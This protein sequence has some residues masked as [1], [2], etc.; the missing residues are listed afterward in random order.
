M[1]LSF[2]AIAIAGFP[3]VFADT[4]YPKGHPFLTDVER[5]RT[6]NRTR[7]S[8]LDS[9]GSRQNIAYTLSA[10]G[11]VIY[12]DDMSFGPESLLLE[13]VYN[14]TDDQPRRRGLGV[15]PA[16][17]WPDATVVYKYE[18]CEARELL[19]GVVDSAIKEWKKGAPYLNFKEM[20]PSAH[21][22]ESEGILTITKHDPESYWCWSV[23]AWA[24]G[25]KGRRMNLQWLSESGG[26]S[27]GQDLSTAVHEF[28]HALGL[29][30]EHQRPDREDHI[31][32]KCENYAPWT[33]SGCPDASYPA[34]CSGSTDKCCDDWHNYDVASTALFNKYGD[35]DCNSIMHYNANNVLQS[36]PGCTINPST[37]PTQGDYDA[38]CGIY[39]NECAPWKAVNFCTT[40]KEEECGT[41]NPISGLNKCDISTSCI[42]TGGKFHCACRAGYKADAS[43]SDIT[44]HFRLPWDNYRHLVFV[45]ENTACNTLCDNP[46]GF[47]PELCAEVEMRETCPI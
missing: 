47:S 40:T 42:A 10:A 8:F 18:S 5:P 38:I 32:V 31:S 6:Q 11:D 22:P 33:V 23:V 44:K 41:C 35:Y 37:L 14:R 26:R 46:H 45:P 16:K 27:C 34:C 20:A 43:G 21:D 4:P 28:G 19:Q 12:N 17:A 3:L 13:W 1:L 15:K 2:A 36:K 29:M 39:H 7:A 24:W 30:H 25:K 9:E